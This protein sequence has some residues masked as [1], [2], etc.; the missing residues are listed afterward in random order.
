MLFLDVLGCGSGA[1]ETTHRSSKQP[2]D[3]RLHHDWDIMSHPPSLTAGPMPPQQQRIAVH[4]THDDNVSSNN[5]ASS[6]PPRAACCRLDGRERTT[7]YSRTV[8]LVLAAG[9]LISRGPW[10]MDAVATTAVLTYVHI[11]VLFVL[12]THLY[13]YAS[14]K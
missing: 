5:N 7:Y 2:Q 13:I 3:Q 1:G 8:V 6:I 9:E 14:C 4:C 12:H 11:H 10:P